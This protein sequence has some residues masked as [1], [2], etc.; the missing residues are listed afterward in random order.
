M[1]GEIVSVGTEILLGQIVDANAVDLGLVFAETGVT[2]HFRQTVGDHHDRLVSAL[3][4][5]LTRADVV[6]TIGGLGPTEDDITRTAIA[7]AIGQRL[8]TDPENEDRLREIFERRNIP[9]TEAQVRQAQRPEQ[10]EVIPN[11]NGTAPGL[12]CPVGEQVVIALPGPRN[13]FGPMIRG[14]VRDFLAQRSG[15]EPIVSRV[16]RIVGLGESQVEAKLL[17][18]MHSSDPT[19]APYAKI[20]EVHLRL[21]TRQSHVEGLAQFEAEIRDRLGS[22]V[23][24]VGDESLEEVTIDEMA[25]RGLTLAVAESCTGGGLGERLTRVAGVSTVFQG[26]FLTYQDSVKTKLLGVPSE[27]LATEGAVS[28]ACARAMAVG[29]R[30]RLAGTHALSITGVAGEEPMHENGIEKPS[31]LVFIGLATPDRVVAL[32]FQFAGNRDTIRARAVQNALAL[33]RKDVL[34]L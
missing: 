11:P 15:E 29:A 20:G 23:Y 31:G 19:V 25:Q 12:I 24:G 5:A 2:H 7:E 4:L 18:L 30:E 27:I 32:R 16:L 22:H 8:V 28:E 26:G 33:L 34:G 10:A 13:E 3:R 1:R 14:R 9:W 6:V 21:T 17:D